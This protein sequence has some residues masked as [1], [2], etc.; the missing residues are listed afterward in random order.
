MFVI[1]GIIGGKLQIKFPPRIVVLIS[2]VLMALGCII[3]AFCPKDLTIYFYISYA[4]IASAGFGMCYN[5]SV[6]LPQKWFYD[7]RGFA[8]GIVVSALGISCMVGTPLTNWIFS[9]F[10]F[11][12]SFIIIGVIFFVIAFAVSFFMKAPPE[13]FIIV[14]NDSNVTLST[15]Q[16]RPSEIIKTHQYYLLVICMICATISFYMIN[17][18][19]MLLGEVKGVAINVL[20]L[21]MMISSFANS[22]GRF[23]SSTVSDIIGR[24]FTIMILYV[25]SF[26][27]CFGAWKLGGNWLVPCFALVCFCYGGCLA[28]FPA[29]ASDF[30]GI[31]HS[32]AN[33]GLIMIGMGISSTVAISIGAAFSNANMPLDERCLPAS[34]IALAGAVFAALLRPIK[35][36]NKQ[37]A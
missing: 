23:V 33:Y 5:Q 18:I 3:S 20:L 24:R 6:I 28:T 16:Y 37:A 9:T 35:D 26:I 25:L 31:L 34:I 17:P 22:I 29:I 12:L 8:S 2:G 27:G 4:I 13:G 11:K 32:G 30:Y 14:S 21:G 7:K 19:W 10:R 15:R 36:K 1:G